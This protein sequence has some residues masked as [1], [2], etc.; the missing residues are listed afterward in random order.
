MTTLLH[1]IIQ[2]RQLHVGILI[3]DK[4]EV[5]DFC[6][7]FEALSVCRHDRNGT[8]ND[9]SSNKN[10]KPTNNDTKNKNS[11][12]TESPF[13]VSLLAETMDPITTIGGMQVLPHATLQKKECPK[14]DI[15]ILPGGFGTREARCNPTII[16]F[17]KHQAKHVPILASVCTGAMLLAE[18]NILEDGARITTHWEMIDTLQGWYPHLHVE[19]SRSVIRLDATTSRPAIY[20]S[21]GISAGIDMS[22]WIIQDLLGEEISRATAKYMEYPY[23]DKDFARRIEL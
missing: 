21:A 13:Q 16:E 22:F 23:P 12:H 3:F 2:T 10:T 6:G 4:V 9:N 8:N 7:P 14:L 18:A 1:D 20:T 15:L 5:L 11:N 19:K 17:I